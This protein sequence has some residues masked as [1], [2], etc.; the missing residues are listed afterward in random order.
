MSK[1]L[2]PYTPF[3][4]HIYKRHRCILRD[5]R[6]LGKTNEGPVIKSSKDVKSKLSSQGRQL[7]YTH[8][9]LRWKSGPVIFIGIILWGKRE[10]HWNL[11]CKFLLPQFPTFLGPRDLLVYFTDCEGG[12]SVDG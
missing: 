5:T 11:W 8:L 9:H 4:V 10:R 7:P 6:G 2:P 1:R 3:T 12:G